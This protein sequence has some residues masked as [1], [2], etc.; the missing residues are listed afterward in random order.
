[1]AS[2]PSEPV[3]LWWWGEDEA[4]GLAS[5]VARAAQEHERAAGVVVETRLLRHDQVIPSLPAAAERGDTP[6]VHFLWNGIYHIEHAW[7]GL[8]APLEDHL[9]AE[10]VAAISGGPQSRFRGRTYRAAWY[11]IPVVWV[12]NRTLLAR[13]GIDS[14]PSTWD[15]LAEAC[16]RLRAAGIAPIVAG[17]GEGD[18]SVWWLTHILTQAF[19]LGT[20]AAALALGQRS[21][22]EAAHGRAWHELERFVRS[23]WVDRDHLTLTLWDAFERFSAGAGAF[24]LASGPMFTKCRQRLG[25]AVETMTAPRIGAGRLAALPIVDSQGLGLPARSAAPDAGAVLLQFLVAPSS[26]PSL[27]DAA[28]L[29]G[30]DEAPAAHAPYFPNLLPLRLHFDVCAKIGQ[31]VIAGRLDARSACVEA[32]RRCAAWRAAEA[33]R[34]PIYEEWIS[35]VRALELDRRW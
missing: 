20:D 30:P 22:Q 27:F 2:L 14:A 24:T 4:P 31:E 23:R 26:G 16:E 13:A 7:S 11:L 3:R 1:V 12:A 18:F 35:D 28:G 32:D 21:W 17:D 10:T 19:D 34:M 25:D 15:E 9:P 33:E 6:D 8:L 29:Q 5:W